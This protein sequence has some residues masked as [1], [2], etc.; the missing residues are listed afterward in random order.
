MK[1]LVLCPQ[2]ERKWFTAGICKITFL[3]GSQ[4]DRA[5]QQEG[6][7]IHTFNP[8]LTDLQRQVL[9]LLGVPTSVYRSVS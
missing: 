8:E 9:G 6:E 5:L 7:T 1:L 3:D 2:F 4:L